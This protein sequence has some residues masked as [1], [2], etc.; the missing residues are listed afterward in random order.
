VEGKRF[1]DVVGPVPV[2]LKTLVA[3]VSGLEI[4]KAVRNT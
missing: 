2:E 1:L 3:E 4:R